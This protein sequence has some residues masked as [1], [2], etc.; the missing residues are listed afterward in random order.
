[1]KT[2]PQY[3][4]GPP[5]AAAFRVACFVLLAVWTINLKSADSLQ[6]AVMTD[7]G[8]RPYPLTSQDKSLLEN[9]TKRLFRFF[10]EHSDPATGLVDDRARSSGLRYQPPIP[11]SIAATGFG[12]T[13]LSIAPECGWLSHDKARERIRR[14][15][16][17]LADRAPQVHGWFYH[18]MDPKTGE[19][20]YSSE[21]SSIDTALLLCGVLEARQRFSEDEEIRRLADRIYERVDFQ[22]MLNGDPHL[23][24]H[25][26]KP[27]SGFIQ[28]R[29]DTYSEQTVLYLL[30]IG[31]RGRPISAKS[32]YR[33]KRPLVTYAD[34]TYISG[35]PLFT[36]QY[37]H[38]WVDYRG[39]REKSFP[40]TDYFENSIAA[41]RAHRAFCMS[42]SGEFPGFSSNV[43]GITAS[44]SIRGYVDWGGPPRDPRI[45]GTVVPSAAGG[46][47][48]F[49]PDICLPALRTMRAIYGEKIYGRFG[50]VDAFNPNNGWINPDV[51]GIDV[52]IILLSAE[53]LI[54]ERV[55]RWFMRNP[56]IMHALKMVGLEKEP[57]AAG[58][59]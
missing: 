22:W 24:S 30:A 29:W 53:N 55:W 26:W 4:S 20:R 13:A 43:W 18:F 42:L 12:L 2:A 56:E 14:S 35:G 37:S 40:H 50:F 54:N 25:G 11:A 49:T 39:R 46:A 1:M 28:H 32:W 21:V 38:A 9:L 51:I 52:G 31:S 47:L 57:P 15:L 17:F 36:H 23:L 10:D 41:T 34:F 33:W 19:R 48:M 8:I 44:D 7:E 58:N 3:P 59:Y 5:V 6:R 16:R 45:D 27:E